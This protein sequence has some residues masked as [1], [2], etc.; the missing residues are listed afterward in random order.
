MDS[1]LKNNWVVICKS[2]QLKKIPVSLELLGKQFVLYRYKDEVIALEDRCPHRNVPLSCGRTTSRG[3]KCPYHGWEFDKE[4][5]CID[6]PGLKDFVSKPF[7]K[8]KNYIA[9]EKGGLVW[10]KEKSFQKEIP[11]LPEYFNNPK[12]INFSFTSKSKVSMLNAL[13]NFLDGTH[14]NF[15]HAGLIRSDN[16]RKKVTAELKIISNGLEINYLGEDSQSGAISKLFEGKRTK[17]IAR[18]T[19]PNIAELEY[20]D[21]KGLRAAFFVH[22]K[23]INQQITEVI[24]NVY[25][26]KIPI[27]NWLIK[28]ILTPFLYIALQQDKRILE[29]QRLNIAKFGKEH[30]INTKLD[31]LRPYLKILLEGGNIVEIKNKKIIIY[32]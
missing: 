19:M 14:T 28:P 24:V 22:F 27:L 3:I 23:V 32:L 25:I 7:Y 12:Y 8:V 26:R 20:Y 6:I 29:K 10:V 11:Y 21:N 17:S 30:F 31:L 16:K 4:G 13:E 1:I 15:V 5:N 2:E 18:F 9:Y